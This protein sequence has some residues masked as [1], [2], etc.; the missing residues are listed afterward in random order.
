MTDLNAPLKVLLLEDDPA[1]AE[2]VAHTLRRADR[3]CEVRSVSDEGEFTR[4]LESLDPH[5]VLSDRGVPGFGAPDAL[6]AVQSQKPECAFLLVSGGLDLTLTTCL[7]SG[8][9]DFVNKSELSRLYTAIQAALRERTSFLKLS[10]RQR[11]VVKLLAGGASTKAIA[12]RLG[13]SVKTVE[14]HRSQAMKRLGLGDIAS[15]VR[16]AVRLGIV[17]AMNGS[18]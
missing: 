2:L 10:D 16:Y 4:E 11:Q 5:V 18:H 6:R 7:R 15:V 13:V 1:D 9:V 3:S 14:T 12:S 17:S 8:A